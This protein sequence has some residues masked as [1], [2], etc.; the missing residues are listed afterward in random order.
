MEEGNQLGVILWIIFGIAILAAC[1]IISMVL[2][3][4]AFLVI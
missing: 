3:L 1:G 4:L 2:L